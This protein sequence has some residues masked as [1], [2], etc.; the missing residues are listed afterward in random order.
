MWR[1]YVRFW[2]DN[3]P[4][5]VGDELQFHIEM[6]QREY[7]DRGMT[8][9]E[10]RQAAN[11]RFGDVARVNAELRSH[12]TRRDRDAL[13][14][15]TVGSFL[16][17]FRYAIRTLRRAPGFTIAAVLCLGLGTGATAAVFAVVAHLLFRPLPVANP[18]NLVV[19]GTISSGTTFPGDNSYLNFVDIRNLRTVL[20]DAAAG[21]TWP[22]S[23]RVGDHTERSLFQAVSEN[24]W[25]MLGVS[26]A[27]G[28]AFTPTEALGRE[29]VIVISYRLWRRELGGAPGVVGRSE[30]RQLTSRG[31]SPT[32]R[33]TVGSRPPS[34]TTSIRPSSIGCTAARA[35]DSRS[36]VACAMESRSRP[37]DRRWICW[38]RSCSANTRSRMTASGL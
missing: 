19:I 17:D 14:R 1:R 9:D 24:F 31:R 16:S 11:A 6:R 20:R 37:L 28:R 32:S 12:D 13:R 23:L 26:M 27:Q 2:G 4:A 33:R 3:V 21:V 10:A 8:S 15:V 25:S 36:S 38:Q 34:F 7:E 30:S 29:R 18:G 5:D 22:V 35:G